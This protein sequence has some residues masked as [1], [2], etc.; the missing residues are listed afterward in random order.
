MLIFVAVA[1]CASTGLDQGERDARPM[2]AGASPDVPADVAFDSVT[3]FDVRDAA[4]AGP[5]VPPPPPTCAPEAIIDL[6][7]DGEVRADVLHYFGNNAGAS[8]ASSVFVRGSSGFITAALAMTYTPTTSTR[9]L[10]SIHNPGTEEG[11]VPRV[12][13]LDRC[14]EEVTRQLY[15]SLPS[16]GPNMGPSEGVLAG[17]PLTIVVA[18]QSRQLTGRFELTVHELPLVGLGEVCSLGRVPENSCSRETVCVGE[19]F[20]PPEGVCMARG[21][22]GSACRLDPPL[23]DAGLSC[24]DFPNN[25]RSLCRPSVAVG[26]ACRDGA[27]ADGTYCALGTCVERG[28]LDNQCRFD[29]TCDAPLTCDGAF[30]RPVARLGDACMP[31]PSRGPKCLGE[32]SCVGHVCVLDGSEGAACQGEEQT[33]AVGLRCRREAFGGRDARCLV[34]AELGEECRARSCGEGATCRRGFVCTQDG[35][36]GGQC[37]SDGAPCDEGL[38]CAEVRIADLSLDN[39]CQPV[40]AFDACQG[41][42]NHACPIGTDCTG[43]DRDELFC[44]PRTGEENAPCR[45]EGTACETGLVCRYT[46]GVFAAPLCVSL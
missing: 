30:C 36:Q 11:F 23:C 15:D 22:E 38:A 24:S 1:G 13:V 21:P 9:L 39:T 32:Q 6:H 8:V 35:V 40:F 10:L 5:D 27:C 4:D 31:S 17:V 41:P 45:I 18:G 28:T 26:G 7:E 37:R 43:L 42:P 14:T 33:C 34:P 19:G 16:A 25:P 2:D 12:W 20:A 44:L 29:G 46:D 3:L